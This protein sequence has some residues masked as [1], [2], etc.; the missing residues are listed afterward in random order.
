[1]MNEAQFENFAGGATI[2]LEAVAVE[3]CNNNDSNKT[4]EF[5][6]NL[7]YGREQDSAVVNNL[8]M[9]KLIMFLMAEGVLKESGVFY[10]TQMDVQVSIG[11]ERH[12]IIFYQARVVPERAYRIHLVNCVFF[13]HKVARS[14]R[15]KYRKVMQERGI[16]I[17]SA[18]VEARSRWSSSTRLHMGAHSSCT[19]YL[20]ATSV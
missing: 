4:M 2:S 12:T 15:R 16:M 11:V 1:M 19:V 8:I 17:R 6:T 7:S 13:V 18:H 20:I 3:F 14:M 9:E 5:H 10:A